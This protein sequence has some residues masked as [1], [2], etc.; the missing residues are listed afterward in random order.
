MARNHLFTTYLFQL[1]LYF[2]LV[3]AASK[4][5]R[6]TLSSLSSTF[7]SFSFSFF[8][9]GFGSLRT[10]RIRLGRRVLRRD[11]PDNSVN[12]FAKMNKKKKNFLLNRRRFPSSLRTW[13]GD[14]FLFIYFFFGSDEKEEKLYELR[15]NDIQK[16]FFFLAV[17]IRIR[18]YV[19][20]QARIELGG[21]DVILVSFKS[22]ET[23][24]V[25]FI[26][27]SLFDF[28]YT[29]LMLMDRI[30]ILSVWHLSSFCRS[31]SF[32]NDRQRARRSTEM[33]TKKKTPIGFGARNSVKKKKRQNSRGSDNCIFFYD[34]LKRNSNNNNNNSKK[35]NGN[36][37]KF[38]LI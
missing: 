13:F 37:F 7:F 22:K 25:G 11:P 12:D 14:S 30:K 26:T 35:K 27:V 36:F 4:R 17:R 19:R 32:P 1:Y 31:A 28:D 9:E 24:S 15:E 10:I 34:S 5:R 6:V 18:K 3:L 33:E 29:T 38:F 2:V 20:D 21:S 16:C 23:H 8:F